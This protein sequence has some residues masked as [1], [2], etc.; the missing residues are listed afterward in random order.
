MMGEL[1]FVLKDFF[2]FYFEN[3]FFFELINIV[4][5]GSLVIKG[6]GIGIV[7]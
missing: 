7:Y 4:I 6:K 2:V 1:I 3:V 5:V